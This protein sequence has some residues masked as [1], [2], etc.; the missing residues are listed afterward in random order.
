MV[1][2][3]LRLPTLPDGIDTGDEVIEITNTV[4]E[5]SPPKYM[6]VALTHAARGGLLIL[7]IIPRLMVTSCLLYLGLRYLLSTRSVQ[8]LILNFLSLEFILLIPEAVASA[9]FP[10]NMQERLGHLSFALPERHPEKEIN[11]RAD[12]RS[13]RRASRTTDF[14]L[15]G[16]LVAFFTIALAL[17]IFSH[18]NNI[19]PEYDGD[20]EKLCKEGMY[21][22]GSKWCTSLRDCFP[23]GDEAEL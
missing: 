14:V 1:R 20:L 22:D 4:H 16:M 6:V 7:I 8:E 10:D 2:K 12:G 17:F 18:K 9:L 3:I 19:I 5:G 11:P 13:P 21:M 23:Y 15:T